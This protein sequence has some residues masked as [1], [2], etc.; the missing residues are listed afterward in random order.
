MQVVHVRFAEAARSVACAAD[1]HALEVGEN[2]IVET[3][4][5]PTFGVVTHGVL[6]NPFYD[7][8]GGAKLPRVVRL[9]TRDDE[10]AYAHKIAHERAAREYC[11]EKIAERKLEMK[12]GQVEQQPGARKTIFYFTAERRVDFRGLVQDLAGKF[13]CRVE[14]RQIGARDDAGMHGGCGPCGRSLCC[15]TFLRKFEPV[16]MKMAKEQ[17]LSLNP[18]KISGMCGRLMCCLKYEHEPRVAE[19]GGGPPPAARCGPGGG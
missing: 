9:A 12:L 5:G 19:R 11:L 8:L 17:G 7:G 2:C 1:G 13:H 16:S 6:D 3:G 14:L 10:E 18:S 4:S 15:S